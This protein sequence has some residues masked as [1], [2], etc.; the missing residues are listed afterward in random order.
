MSRAAAALALSLLAVAA[1]RAAAD[2][3]DLP[4]TDQPGR[5][6]V[7]ILSAPLPLVAGLD[8]AGA[9][10]ADRLER[11]GYSRVHGRR[12]RAA[13][14]FFWGYDVFWIHQRPHRLGGE[15][16]RFGLFGLTLEDGRIT[17]GLTPGGESFAL[18]EPGRPLPWGRR[19]VEPELLAESADAD[20]APRVPIAFD[21]LPER[22]WRPLLAAEDARFFD[23]PGLDGISI[24]RAALANLRAG[25]VAQGGSTITQQL[26]KMRDLTPQ[27]TLG[28]K[29][30]EAVRSLA[31]EAE[32]DK[33]EILEAYLDHVYL[34]HVGGLAIHGY[35]AGA[36]AYFGKPANRLTL[37][38]A[39]LLAAVIQAPN[40]MSPVRHPGRAEGRRQWV[41]DRLA[42]LGWA[43]D[44]AI[45]RARTA[46]AV[47]S[48]RPA[49]QPAAGFVRW[50][51][52]VSADAAPSRSRR[53]RGFVAETTLDAQLQRHAER[54]VTAGL[55]GLLRRHPRLHDEPLSAALVALDPLTGA[56]LAHVPGD[57][58]RRGD[59]FDRVRQA[60][61]QPGST[62]KPL[63]L[64]EAF[65]DCGR[66]EPLTPATRVADRPLVLDL[67]SGP[68][69]PENPGRDFRGVV[70]LR[71]AVSESLN[72]PFARVAGWCGFEETAERAREAGLVLPEPPPPA[73]ALGAVETTP[74]ALA[75]A[76]TV[77][78]T[79][80]TAMRPFPV[81]RIE[82]PGGSALAGGAPG[83]RRVVRPASAYL[84]RDLL[85]TAVDR[86]RSRSAAIAGVD[87]VGK[88]GT[89]SSARD[90]W[91]AGDAGSVVAVVWVGLDDGSPLGLSG[92]AAAVPIWRDFMTA[93]V[94]A[95]PP[96]TVPRPDGV[97][98]AW[99]QD[100]TG[101]RVREGR[102][103]SHPEL[104]RKGAEPPRRRFWRGDPPLPP[105]L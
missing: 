37:G 55:D 47:A 18:P 67:P 35:G 34:G 49:R 40:R 85:R 94:A 56:I 77:L 4:L 51:G 50:A 13:G 41:L 7:R 30:S 33:E 105:V 54:A 89:S 59:R 80:G 26:I 70:D 23:H 22:V 104:F 102:R 2:D 32:H 5:S 103:G 64:L 90:A 24:A 66:E 53:G 74:L 8:V 48:H 83:G 3:L 29:M 25:G 92:A 6:D 1:P 62:V 79:P 61:R 42:E 11:L 60:E 98:T 65:D 76:Y 46:P 97:V 27:R 84:I 19:W 16:H 20:R 36:R 9:G 69:E 96:R 57:P 58:R 82:R 38:E 12:P 71:Q 72:V 93:A 99:V 87:V 100:S 44:D 75:E 17:G 81:Q 14:E 31:V 43:D 86:G 28:R 21:E 52:E 10:L 101:R 95:R 88:T 68:W 78:A 39:A 91:F 15:V 73:F 45:R 63:V